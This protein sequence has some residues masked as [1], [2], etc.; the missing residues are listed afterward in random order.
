MKRRK[1][2]QFW[3]ED[4]NDDSLVREIISGKKTTTVCKVDEYDLS[5]GEYDDGGY[6]IGELVEVYDLKQQLRCI[7]KI[8]E[9]YNVRFGDIPEKLWRGEACSSAE[10]FREAHRHCWPDYDLTDDFEMIANH[11]ELI[12]VVHP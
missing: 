11:F 6:L 4:E 10:H 8:T 2:I 12:E 9:V 3:G 7:I 1:R 5:I